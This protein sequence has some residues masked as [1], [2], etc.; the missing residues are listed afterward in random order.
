M[1]YEKVRGQLLGGISLFFHCAEFRS[2]RF[3]QQMLLLALLSHHSSNI[4]IVSNNSMNIEIL[5]LNLVFL[6]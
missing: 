6:K 5:K 3:V 2:V 1:G 4:N